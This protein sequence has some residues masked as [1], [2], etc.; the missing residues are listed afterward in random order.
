MKQTVSKKSKEAEACF[1]VIWY[2]EISPLEMV[3][4]DF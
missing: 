3:S 4:A 2:C 1:L